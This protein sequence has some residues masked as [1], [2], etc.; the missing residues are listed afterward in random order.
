MPF[1]C[2]GLSQQP[3]ILEI[4]RGHFV[5][6][7]GCSNLYPRIRAINTP[8]IKIYGFALAGFDIALIR[9]DGDLALDSS[10]ALADIC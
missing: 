4:A 6:G 9:G 3:G 5:S 1:I 10:P 2:T 7:L 8:G